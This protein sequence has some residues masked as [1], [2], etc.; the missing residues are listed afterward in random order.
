M[1]AYRHGTL[2]MQGA[3]TPALRP[4]ATASAPVILF[5]YQRVDHLQRAV[6]SLQANPEAAHTDIVFCCDAAKRPEVQARVD[7]VRAFVATV[8]GFRSVRLVFREHNFGLARSVVDG[9]SQML[10][11][12]GRVI[13]LEDDLELSPHFLRF[14]NEALERYRDDSRVASI[15]GYVYPT[16]EELPETFFLEGA[17]CWGWATWSRG[18]AQ[19]EPD[20]AKLLS[21][22]RAR[23]LCR[24]FDFDGEYPYTEMLRDQIA[25]RNSSWAILWHASCYLKGL[26]TLYPGRS[27]VQNIGSDANA[28]HGNSNAAFARPP[29]TMPVPVRA[30]PVEPSALGRQA[31]VKFF[32][33]QRSWQTRLKSTAR[34]VIRRRA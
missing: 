3:S 10:H 25:G 5:A 6:A 21:E 7:A 13:V 19:F 27:L 2:T 12:H 18:W 30:V 22:L 14:M 33:A 31:F 4:A 15:H 9:V 29:T 26:L 24:H 16:G 11:E 8:G 17:D 23:G 1:A 28:T 32:A 20:G 34:R